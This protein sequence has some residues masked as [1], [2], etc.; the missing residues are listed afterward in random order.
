[1]LR[2]D[3]RTD[4]RTGWGTKLLAAANNRKYRHVCNFGCNKHQSDCHCQGRKILETPLWKVVNA[5]DA[6][7]PLF[8]IGLCLRN[9]KNCWGPSRRHASQKNVESFL[10][11]NKY[12]KV[13]KKVRKCLKKIWKC[14]KKCKK[15]KGHN[16]SLSKKGLKSG[17]YLKVSLAL[18]PAVICCKHKSK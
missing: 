4:R 14:L 17:K 16:G 9:M 13:W 2:M 10:V 1:M 5:N 12:S 6:V 3:E 15:K 11:N 8:V 18:H 7:N